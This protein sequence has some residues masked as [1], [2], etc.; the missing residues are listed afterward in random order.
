MLSRGALITLSA[1][2]TPRFGE[3]RF[4]SYVIRE[5]GDAEVLAALVS[6]KL[7]PFCE[8]LSSTH[9]VQLSFRRQFPEVDRR[10]FGVTCD[11]TQ[12]PGE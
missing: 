5:I 4:E 10:Q 7:S 3:T 2:M 8:S 1:I 6:E 12:S 11:F 9:A